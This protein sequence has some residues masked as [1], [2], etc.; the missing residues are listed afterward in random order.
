MDGWEWSYGAPDK[1]TGDQVDEHSEARAKWQRGDVFDSIFINKN[2]TLL[3]SKFH[4]I[5]CLKVQSTLS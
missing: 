4:W 5:L 1:F 2:R 3:W